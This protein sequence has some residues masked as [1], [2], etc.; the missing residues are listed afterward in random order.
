MK[1]NRHVWEGWTVQSFIDELE[2]TF[3]MIMNSWEKPFKTKQEVKN[4]CKDNQPYYKKS[5]PEVAK[6]FIQKA[7]L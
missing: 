5:I 3:K 6:Y 4:W 2:P 1:N 7:K